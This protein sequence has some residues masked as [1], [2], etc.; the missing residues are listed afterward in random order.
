MEQSRRETLVLFKSHVLELSRVYEKI[1]A[2]LTYAYPTLRAEFEKDQMKLDRAVK[3]RGI[4]TFCVDLPALGKHLDRSLSLGQY[5]PPGIFL[6]RKISKGVELPRFLG[7][8]YLLVFDHSGKLKEDYDVAAIFF[9]RQILYAAKKAKLQCSE[10]NVRTE[11]QQF[12]LADSRLPTPER[13][14]ASES[15]DTKE[16]ESTYAGFSK[17]SLY[18]QRVQDMDPNL[19]TQLSDLLVNLDLV[20]GLMI[21]SLGA[22]EYADWRFRHGPGAIAQQ[23]GPVNK[24]DWFNWSERLEHAF[25]LADC[26][27]HSYAFWA[28]DDEK[29]VIGSEEPY[30][31]LI[32]VRKTFTKPRLIACEPSEHQWCQQNIWHY[33]CERSR[34]TWISKFVRFNDQ[35]L[36]QELCRSGSMSGRLFTADLS[37]ASDSVTCHAV[38]QLFRRN[39]K[40]LLALQ[41]T[42]TRFIYQDL[43]QSVPNLVEL[44]KFSTMG[45]ACTFPVETL[46]FLCVTLAAVLTVRR[47][48]VTLETIESLQGE[49]AIFGDDIIGP[50]D[51]RE[52]LFS[53]L[54]ILDFEVNIHKSFWIG[55][56]RESCGVDSFDGHVLTPA[57][58]KQLSSR[59]PES[60]AS[61]VAVAN[62]FYQRMLVFTSTYLASTIP[63]VLPAVQPDSGVFGL[64][65]RVPTGAPSTFKVRWNQE[66][67]RRECY[68]PTPVGVVRRMPT[69]DDSALLQY[70]TER[71]EP[72]HPWK[73]GY[74]QR[75]VLKIRYRWVPHHLLSAQ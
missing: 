54:E 59:K 37:A 42:R 24:Y 55:K 17:S 44:R 9:L 73:P 22:Y 56:F 38:G 51:S 20:S 23:A 13:F 30:S 67:Q 27:Y 74:L 39:P 53:A 48:R 68:L 29:D 62:N 43:V 32:A 35:T 72:F 36:N 57:F 15:P 61:T 58:W 7:A 8:L 28:A 52:L 16:I 31:R 34:K 40:L 19:R 5:I 1:F 50:E 71:P 18:N 69:G 2:D 3:Q 60:I 12:F 26:G 63:L 10:E 47:K 64:V 45:S 46:L 49:V 11:V 21:S 65:T 75:P 14:W 66:Y 70:F 41:A 33:L 4:H 6:S 25:P